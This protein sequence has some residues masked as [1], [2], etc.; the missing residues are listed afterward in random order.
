MY[1]GN[2]AIDIKSARS[3]VASIRKDREIPPLKAVEDLTACI[4]ILAR[5]PFDYS[6]A[7]AFAIRGTAYARGMEDNQSSFRD[8][9]R[10]LGV[11]A[12]QRESSPKLLNLAG[13]VRVQI[14]FHSEGP[15]RIRN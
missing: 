15:A 3:R 4:E 2:H 12:R 6:L 1:Q 10:A 7:E 13:Q 9:R 5:R 11:I 8:W 14:A